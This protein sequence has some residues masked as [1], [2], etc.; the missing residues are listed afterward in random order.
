MNNA[1]GNRRRA[2]LPRTIASRAI[3]NLYTESYYRVH[4]PCNNRAN[5]AV[6]YESCKNYTVRIF[7]VRC[8]IQMW[9]STYCNACNS[10]RSAW[11]VH[12]ASGFGR[13]A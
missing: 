12:R 8:S 5:G 6:I 11:I 10:G 3:G 1:I 7:G 4:K 2:R 9:C 13:R